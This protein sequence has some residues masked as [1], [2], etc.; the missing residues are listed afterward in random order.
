MLSVLIT[1][2]FGAVLGFLL[3]LIGGAGVIRAVK[4]DLLELESDV[5]S[6]NQRLTREQKAR[7]GRALQDGQR[8]NLEEAEILAAQAKAQAKPSVV[9][10]GRAGRN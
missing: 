7:A 3:A 4:R 5:L 2:L 6:L 9:L 8:S 10:I 1:S